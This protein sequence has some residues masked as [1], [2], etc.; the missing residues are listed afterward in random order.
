MNS[1]IPQGTF[2]TRQKVLKADGSGIFLSLYDFQI[3]YDIEFFGKIHHLYDCNEYTREFYENLGIPQPAPEQ[4]LSD[5]WER[6]TLNKY[7]PVKDHMLKDFM[8]HKL[9]G[10]RVPSQK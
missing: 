6:K 7:I 4:S 10:G 8:E 5:N 1:G 2:L 3:G 9:G